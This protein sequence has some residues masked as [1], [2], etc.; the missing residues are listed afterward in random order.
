MTKDEAID[1]LQFASMCPSLRHLRYYSS[2]P[3]RVFTNR[4]TLSSLKSR[5]VTVWWKWGHGEPYYI[6]N[7]QTGRWENENDGSEPTEEAFERM[8]SEHA[9][10]RKGWTEETYKGW[11]SS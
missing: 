2:V 11:V 3:L 1:I 5:D 4:S 9:E 6:L 8:L 10:D 7:L